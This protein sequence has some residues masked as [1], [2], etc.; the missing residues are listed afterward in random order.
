MIVDDQTGYG[1]TDMQP[2]ELYAVDQIDGISISSDTSLRKVYIAKDNSVRYSQKGLPKIPLILS[3]VPLDQMS[4]KSCNLADQEEALMDADIIHLQDDTAGKQIVDDTLHSESADIV[5]EIAPFNPDAPSL[6]NNAIHEEPA[7]L[8]VISE[9]EQLP[10]IKLQST[11]AHTLRATDSVRSKKSNDS[12]VASLEGAGTTQKKRKKLK[13]PKVFKS[14]H[15]SF[16]RKKNK[17]N[18]SGMGS[19]RRHSLFNLSTPSLPRTTSM[20]SSLSSTSQRRYSAALMLGSL[21]DLSDDNI[22]RE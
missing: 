17:S 6:T 3:P 12:G 21:D 9:D 22:C 19:K 18:D 2:V 4:V 16:K 15:M 10:E 11:P 1:A 8:A 7:D 5:E 13:K 20:A 14:F